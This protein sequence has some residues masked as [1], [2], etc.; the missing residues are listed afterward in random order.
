[1]RQSGRGGRVAAGSPSSGLAALLIALIGLLAGAASSEAAPPRNVLLLISDNQG[2]PDCGCYG[3]NVVQT[4]HLD[5]LA[6]EAIR[7]DYAFATTA[8]CG[9]SRAVIYTGQQTHSNGQYGHGHGYHTFRLKPKVTTVFQRM[10]QAGYRTALLGKQHVTPPE[11]YPFDFNPKVSG[12]DVV[13]LAEAAETFIRESEDQPFFLVIGYSDPHPTSRE[14]DGWGIVRDD[15]RLKRIEY[16]PANIEVPAWLPDVPEVREGLVG[17]YQQ[18]SRM[19]QGVGRVL[20][21]LD[22]LGHADDTL[23]IFTSDHGSSEPGAMA[24]HY[25]PG[26]RVP[27]LVRKPG[28]AGGGECDALVTLADIVPTVLDWTGQTIPDELHGRSLM[29]ILGTAHPEGWDEVCL[30]H[31]CH[32]VTMY[33]PMR[34]IRT[35]RYK[36]IWNIAWRL[37]FPHPID[38]L[39]RATWN[40]ILERKE[41]HCG[42][43]PVDQL[44]FRDEYELYDLETDPDEIDNLAADPEHRD[45]R[46]ELVR[47][48]EAFCRET[49]DP[50]LLRHRFPGDDFGR[51]VRGR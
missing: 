37:Q 8:S 7:F 15:P 22:E 1:M 20:A 18:I 19:D 50:W 16:D 17:Y 11:A 40:G 26:I 29:P 42:R 12:R 34:T 10:Q 35:R 30:T 39:D 45:V 13:G 9:P 27:F 33:Y 23:V 51:H 43:R 46:V 28:L 3:N 48:L 44:M 41:T 36:L 24:N 47:R 4:P 25:E 49:D 32:E 5:R 31:V 14:G 38:T 2:W 21:S 6:A